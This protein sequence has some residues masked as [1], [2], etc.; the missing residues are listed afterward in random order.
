MTA[1]VADGVDLFAD[2]LQVT[3]D[4]RDI[5]V[6]LAASGGKADASSFSGTLGAAVVVNTTR[7]HIEN[8]ANIVVGS[9]PLT[10]PDA[11][12]GSVL[13]RA[14]DTSYVVTGAG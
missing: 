2:S 5:A 9:L 1:T 6:V 14:E 11:N 4:T 7:A 10:D 12:G 8:G 3:A 13:V